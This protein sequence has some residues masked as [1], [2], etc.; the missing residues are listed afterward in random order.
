MKQSHSVSLPL[1]PTLQTSSHRSVH[2][3]RFGC[4]GEYLRDASETREVK[5]HPGMRVC[6][7]VWLSLLSRRIGELRKY[8]DEGR[9]HP[10]RPRTVYI[11]PHKSDAIIP[12][13]RLR[14]LAEPKQIKFRNN[15]IGRAD[16]IS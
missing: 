13:K 12:Q 4:C 15:W 5:C 16:A 9:L 2:I 8:G 10:K 7:K 1:R 11:M 14:E 6:L 3:D